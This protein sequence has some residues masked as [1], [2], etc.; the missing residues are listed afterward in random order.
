MITDED[1]VSLGYVKEYDTTTVMS[2]GCYGCCL[3]RE[4]R[5]C[6]FSYPIGE[7]HCGSNFKGF[8]FKDPNGIGIE[9]AFALARLEAVHG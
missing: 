5:S 4:G 3:F 2:A 1:V 7:I 6:P 8:V 9:P